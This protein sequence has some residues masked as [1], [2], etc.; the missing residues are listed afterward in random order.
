MRKIKTVVVTGSN[1]F[2]GIRLSEFLLTKGLRVVG[3]V[4]SQRRHPLEK[5]KNFISASADIREPA[6]LNAIFKKFSPEAV[7]HTAALLP[8]PGR[9][10]TPHDFFRTNVLG[11]L[12]VLEAA[13]QNKVATVIHSSSMAVYGNDIKYLPVDEKHPCSPAD[14]YGLSKLQAEEISE[15][16]ARTHKIH[17]IILRYSGIF[18]P[19]R[20]DGAVATFVA[21]ALRDKLLKIES[22]ITWDI[23]SVDDVIRANFL[24]WQKASRLKFEK[25]NIGAG[26]GTPISELAEIVIKLTGSCS[27]AKVRAKGLPF[28]FF[29]DITKAKELLGFT[30]LPLMVGIKQ[31]LAN[32]K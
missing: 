27:V 23:I 4:F 31:F 30:P 11:T 12:N 18:G 7:F 19:G 25:L 15:W 20:R 26:E 9:T 21:R 22:D 1:G 17:T 24:A 6:R 13:R 2:V 32:L 29:Y 10:T 5:K 28:C 3:L 14:F 16:Y 8:K